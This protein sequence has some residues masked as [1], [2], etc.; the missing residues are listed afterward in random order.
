MSKQSELRIELLTILAKSLKKMTTHELL[1]EL[2]RR[3]VINNPNSIRDQKAVT[4]AL[5]WLEEQELTES[6]GGIGKPGKKW[7]ISKTGFSK[8]YILSEKEINQALATLSFIP[9]EFKA[10]KK[11]SKFI[12]WITGFARN[13]NPNVCE[14]EI[15]ESF[16]HQDPYTAVYC[17]VEEKVLE[18]IVKAIIEKKGVKVRRKELYIEEDYKESPEIYGWREIFPISIFSY[19]GNLYVGAIREHKG[20]WTYR[21]YLL[22]SLD[23]YPSEEEFPQ[24]QD[25]EFKELVKEK[26]RSGI[27]HPDPKPFL[28]KVVLTKSGG[29]VLECGQKARVF[30]TQIE[31]R[32]RKDGNYEITLVGYAEPRFCT[33]FIQ[34]DFI[35]II[36]LSAEE[37]K[38]AEKRA[39]ELFEGK[40]TLL[41]SNYNENQENLKL[42]LKCMERRVK[43]K[44][45]AL[46]RAVKDLT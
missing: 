23:L 15:I 10:M 13:A 25:R 16:Y 1:S 30:L 44:E 39:K 17:S 35:E 46:K 19:E 3:G 45:T 43:T 14:K 26:L 7:R 21:S 27:D 8:F 20:S 31:S 33:E 9:E 40:K 5:N 42:F 22:G 32:K 38:G 34:K 4:R 24:P 37:F 29:R 18:K 12:E 36:P 6:E 28:F 11:L 2:H 41:P